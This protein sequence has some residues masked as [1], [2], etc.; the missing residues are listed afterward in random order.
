SR[1]PGRGAGRIS[2]IAVPRARWASGR[3]RDRLVLSERPDA[4]PRAAVRGA[5]PD[6][7]RDV[8]PRPVELDLPR[9]PR[10]P[11]P[12]RV[13][14]PRPLPPV[15]DRRLPPGR[16]DIPGPLGRAD[17]VARPARAAGR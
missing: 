11:R 3:G 1:R 10:P 4:P 12:D 16:P 8:G 2:R 14:E 15:R 9:P 17:G 5:R 6:G 13:T 7:A